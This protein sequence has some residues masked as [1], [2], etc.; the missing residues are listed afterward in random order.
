MKSS[1]E[2]ITSAP[3]SASLSLPL[4]EVVVVRGV[5]GAASRPSSWCLPAEVSWCFLLGGVSSGM[6]DVVAS[7]AF[8]FLVWGGM[9]P[10]Y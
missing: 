8:R 5:G 4:W 2:S 7:A 9:V 3:G 1:S 10:A 6:G